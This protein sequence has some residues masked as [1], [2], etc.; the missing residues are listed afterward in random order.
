M[1]GYTCYYQN[2]IPITPAHYSNAY[3]TRKVPF[4]FFRSDRFGHS[5][6]LRVGEQTVLNDAKV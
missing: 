2:L 5:L 6:K 3:T 4:Y 1:Y